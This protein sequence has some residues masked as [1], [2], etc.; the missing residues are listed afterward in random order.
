MPSRSSGQSSRTRL[1][2]QTRAYL[3]ANLDRAVSLAELCRFTG[4]SARTIQYAFGDL[5]GVAPQLYHRARRLN[6]VRQSLQ[7]Q[8]PG[9]TTVTDAAFGHGFW[10]RGRF[11]EA[12]K[13]RFGESPSETLARRPMPGGS[14]LAFAR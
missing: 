1:A 4:A 5:Y 14:T 7:Q 10:H 3:D 13:K 9:E 2:R 6:A 11:S 8:W 12:Y